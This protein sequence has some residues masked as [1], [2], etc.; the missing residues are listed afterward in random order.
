MT[1]SNPLA[2]LRLYLVRH[3]ETEWNRIGRFQGRNDQP[4]NERGRKQAQALAEAL[5][6]ENFE[7]IYSSPLP[8]SLETARFIGAFHPGIPLIEEPNFMEMDLGEFEGVDVR[9]WMEKNQDFVRA[10]AQNP[11]AVRMPGGESLQEVQDRALK[12]LK[13]ISARYVS[14]DTL[15][16]CSHSFVLS[17]LLCHA[18]EI[19]LNR[20]RE[21]KKGTASYSLLTLN[22]GQFQAEM[23]NK[24]SHLEKL[25]KNI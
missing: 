2:N 3:G 9:Q 5:Q 19:P 10:W 23:I 18:R 17:T 21:V 15:L 11:S 20:F 14:G 7:A 24:R 13:T 1:K 22:N 16:I 25:I 4:L 8:R 6:N 12:A